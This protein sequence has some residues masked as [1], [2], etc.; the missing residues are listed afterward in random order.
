MVEAKLL[1][2]N[3]L[4]KMV[5]VKFSKSLKGNLCN[6]IGLRVNHEINLY[7]FESLDHLIDSS[8]FGRLMLCTVVYNGHTN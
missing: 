6:K 5:E 8:N 1:K 2:I 7:Y 4:S 3:I